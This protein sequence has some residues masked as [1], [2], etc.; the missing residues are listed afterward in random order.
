VTS[1]GVALFAGTDPAVVA[2]TAQLAEELGYTSFWLNHPGRTDGIA[3]LRP[4]AEATTSIEL[5]VGV[6]P[7]HLRGVASVVEGV[8]STGLPT[9]RLLVGIGT[10]GPGAFRLARDGVTSIRDALNC[11]VAMGALAAG[12]CRL[13]G[14]IADGVLFNWLTPEYA[15]RSAGWVEEGAVRAGRP[16]PRLYAYVRL[17]LGPGARELIEAEGAR[18]AA[19]SYGPHFERMGAEPLDTAIAADGRGDV[20]EGLAAWEGVVDEV[21]LRFLPASGSLDSHLELVRA[22]ARA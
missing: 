14:E 9:E 17:A 5:G 6:V 19:G 15:R 3:G 2:S 7:L 22:G 10:A 8:R 13:A 11:G 12:A 18:Y 16:R 4:A 20:A 1:R 21:V